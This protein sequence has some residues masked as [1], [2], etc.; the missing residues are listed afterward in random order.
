MIGKIIAIKAFM[1]VE[2]SSDEPNVN[3]LGFNFIFV[4]M[5]KWKTE[6]NSPWADFTNSLEQTH[7]LTF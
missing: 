1:D 5:L 4:A 3:K 7:L 6:N 2:N